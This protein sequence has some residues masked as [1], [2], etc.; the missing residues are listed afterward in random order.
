MFGLGA[1]LDKHL[2]K[3]RPHGSDS[4]PRKVKPDNKASPARLKRGE[5]VSRYNRTSKQKNVDNKAALEERRA[6]SSAFKEATKRYAATSHVTLR[7]EH[8]LWHMCLY[9]CTFQVR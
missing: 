4:P 8:S 5:H 7:A 2:V 3:K 6:Y 1:A 9:A